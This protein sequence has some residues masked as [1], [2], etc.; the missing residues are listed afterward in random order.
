MSEKLDAYCENENYIIYRE[1]LLSASRESVRY[2]WYFVISGYHSDIWK[3]F[4][5]L[6][7][8][9]IKFIPLPESHIKAFLPCSLEKVPICI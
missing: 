6:G 4:S 9:K 2:K 8:K 1:I 7:N 5:W 3:K